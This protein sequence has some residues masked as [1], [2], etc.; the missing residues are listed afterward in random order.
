VVKKKQKKKIKKLYIIENKWIKETKYY[1]LYV[2][3]YSAS[4][5]RTSF[6]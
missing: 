1:H 2:S 6:T 4:Y 3:T 5:I